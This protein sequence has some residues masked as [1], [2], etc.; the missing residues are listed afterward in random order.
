MNAPANFPA[1]AAK[2]AAKNTSGPT[3]VLKCGDSAKVLKSILTNSVS[4][5][6]CDPPYG[7]D[8]GD[9]DWD[10]V[11][12]G[13]GIWRECFRVLKPG[14]YMVA[15]GSPKTSHELTTLL[16]KIGFVICGRLVWE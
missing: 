3:A 8:F 5:I 1:F 15:F 11:I 6:I 10:N 16:Q 14:G 2:L 13:F 7:I 9:F 12:P 4:A